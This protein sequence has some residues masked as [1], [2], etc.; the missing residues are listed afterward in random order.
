M[1]HLDVYSDIACP[2]CFIGKRRLEAAVQQLPA[3]ERPTVR[4]H[5]FQLAP[6]FP[7]G[8]SKPIV[9]ELARK[10]GGEAAVRRAFTQVSAV[11]QQ[12]G[13]PFALDRGHA[14]NTRLAHRAVAWAR[15]VGAEAV[16]VEAL[17]TAYFV[18]GL[19]LSKTDIVAEILG[20]VGLDA[21][22][23]TTALQAGAGNDE[24]DA[25]LYDASQIG[26][27]GVPFFV[28]DQRLA[29]SGAQPESTFLSFL[30][31]GQQGA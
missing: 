21:V 27:T 12:V 6:Q 4:W 3:G 1:A 7:E 8:Q 10:F 19:D 25:D 15:S 11:G 29:M 31:E 18:D 14:V 26:V 9:E 16:A 22:A 5:A 2:W 17:F 30:R 23:A 24:V 13:I 20:A 28:L